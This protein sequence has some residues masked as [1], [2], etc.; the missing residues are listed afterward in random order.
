MCLLNAN[1]KRALWLSPFFVA[2]CFFAAFVRHG[3][4]LSGYVASY[5][6]LPHDSAD[7]FDFNNGTFTWR[8]CCGN[9]PQGT[10]TQTTNGVWI[11]TYKSKKGSL[12]VDCQARMVLS[13]FC[14]PQRSYKYRYSYATVIR[15]MAV[16]DIFFSP[17]METLGK[18]LHRAAQRRPV[19]VASD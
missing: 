18:E 15:S 11:W 1:W 8:T 9:E 19:S 3:K 13:D 12:R 17:W 16:I 10:Y 6:F 5:S 14:R 7:V 2:L 4:N